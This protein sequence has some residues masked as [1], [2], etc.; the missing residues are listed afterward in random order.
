MNVVSL[1]QMNP[2]NQS[3]DER[4]ESSLHCVAE[5]W[6]TCSESWL[7]E[8]IQRVTEEVS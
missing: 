8:F 4:N 6:N 3:Q 2:Y 7:E 1:R 5:S